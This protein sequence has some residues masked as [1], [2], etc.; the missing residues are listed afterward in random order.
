MDKSKIV[1]SKETL[2][3][4][5][6]NSSNVIRDKYACLLSDIQT[7]E[8]LETRGTKQICI[9]CQQLSMAVNYSLM[10]IGVS[11]RAT[12]ATDNAYEKRFHLKNLKTSI[13]ESF[14]SIL[15]FKKA[16]KKSIWSK[17]GIVIND[18]NQVIEELYKKITASL[19][20]FEDTHIN[21]DLRNLTLHYDDDMMR[22]YEATAN[23][24][25]EDAEM[26]SL[27][28]YMDILQSIRFL[29]ALVEASEG[30]Q[31]SSSAVTINQRLGI[32]SIFEQLINKEGKLMEVVE[33]AI[34][35]ASR[36]IDYVADVNIRF[37]KI[38]SFVG[39][40][41]PICASFDELDNLKT[42]L[43]ARMLLQFMIGDL[44]AITKAYLQSKSEEEHKMN[45]RRFVVIQTST[46]VHLYGYNNDEQGKSIWKLLMSFL[47][48]SDS[49]LLK[50][51]ADMEKQLQRLVTDSE[52]KKER[53]LY[54][55]LVNNSNSK[56]GIPDTLRAI[57][58]I[59]P[60]R[61]IVEVNV[62]LVIM[63][64]VGDW[65]IYIMEVLSKEASESRQK[66]ERKIE[67]MFDNLISNLSNSNFPKEQKNQLL[68]TLLLNKEKMMKVVK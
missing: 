51:C 35:E 4:L 40:Q 50:E 17:L 54:V 65:L 24:N 11:I 23:I 64:Q 29:I 25:N 9:L 34:N 15:N 49:V 32:N 7:L 45:L 48:Q 67:N 8:Q 46:L 13:S 61:E 10:D 6:E 21:Q 36:N 26:K 27:C 56:F 53:A 3:R 55:H 19:I 52:D 42:L 14:K 30:M 12:L 31:I 41:F 62:L 22:V 16:R 37:Q 66:S 18:T 43:N 5:L 33:R 39:Q 38:Q 44:A 28:E 59:D 20:L 47:P 68:E 57:D 2:S 1:A 63:K 58:A 60:I